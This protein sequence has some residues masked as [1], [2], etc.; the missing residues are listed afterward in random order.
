MLEEIT[1]GLIGVAL[2]VTAALAAR[3][4]GLP[5]PVLLVG[6]STVYALLP[7]PTVRL[8]PDLV[9]A[10]IIPPLLF[11]AALSSSLVEIRANLRAVVSLSVLL[12]VV[13]ALVTGAALVVVVPGLS[14]AGACALGAALAPP[15]A[16][17]ALSIGRRVGLPDR[18]R[19]VIEGESLFNDATALT[20]YSVAVAATIDGRFDVPRV[21][22]RFLLAVIGGLAVG[23][24]VSWLVGQLRLRIEDPV[25]ETTVS[26]ATPFAAY[27]PA[28]ALHASG[29]LAVVT[30]GLILGSQSRS[31]LSG[32]A[33]LHARAVWRLVDLL[34]EGF[35]FLLIGQQLA[36]VIPAIGHYPLSTVAAATAVTVGAVVLVRPLWLLLPAMLPS[37][38][39]FLSPHPH[40]STRELA[41]L[42]WSGMRGVISLAAVFALPI[43][44]DGAG[45]PHR[46]LLVFCAYVA[47]LV[48][49]VGQGLT[50]G[51]VLHRL[52]VR[53][54]VDEARRQRARARVAA[55]D[56]GLRTLAAVHDQDQLPD[57]LILRLRTAAEERKRR[58]QDSL[59][60]L[61]RADSG[62]P[63]TASL[64]EAFGRVRRTMIEA[65]RDELQLWRDTG[66]LSDASLRLL[67]DELDHEEGA[68]PP[69]QPQP[70]PS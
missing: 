15:D 40:L 61:S 67:E 52:N 55:A 48:T 66:H 9:L 26:L 1:F 12:V 33:R 57:D 64:T 36:A 17:S 53:P 5:A 41:A 8:E 21:A 43:S 28:E 49:L 69:P 25:T 70:P 20:L 16:V 35:V 59:R 37:R 38:L 14:F 7:G 51:P 18:L 50:F 63:P 24:A 42:S 62:R 11:S 46:D 19:T 39:R 30:A 68:L 27:V 22:G 13:T 31:L 6:A 29:V 10:L 32:P 54:D 45:F 65:E 4:F 44:V 23:L 58:S 34:L 56:A 2:V 60:A 3:R 47:V